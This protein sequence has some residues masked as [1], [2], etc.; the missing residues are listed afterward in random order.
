[1][2]ADG[3]RCLVVLGAAIGWV[4]R[5]GGALRSTDDGWTGL[6]GVALAGGSL[7]PGCYEARLQRGWGVTP[8]ER[9]PWRNHWELDAKDH[10]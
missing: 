7:T 1:M 2:D 3:I 6:P 10:G 8:F 9:S 4:R 5:F